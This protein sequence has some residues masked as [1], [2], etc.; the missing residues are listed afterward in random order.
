MWLLSKGFS[1][2]TLNATPLPAPPG[3]PHRGICRTQVQM[4]QGKARLVA[5]GRCYSL[6][7][8]YCSLRGHRVGTLKA[9][10]LC[11]LPLRFW[12]LRNRFPKTL[13][14]SADRGTPRTPPCG[15]G[16][17]FERVSRLTCDALNRQSCF[18]NQTHEVRVFERVSRLTYD[19]LNGQSYAPN[20]KIFL[21]Y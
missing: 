7:L 13:V 1:F 18:A 16:S 3:F 9:D 2:N 15:V 17:V 8:L 14:P 4:L 5:F 20:I 19:A 11:S 12:G 10:F 6:H 21:L